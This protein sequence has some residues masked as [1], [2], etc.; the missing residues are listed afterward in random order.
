VLRQ[1]YLSFTLGAIR[2]R[3]GR[4]ILTALGIG[5]GVAAVLILT[6]IGTGVQKYVVGQF[7]QFGTNII[8]VQPGRSQTFGG[9]LGTISS[10]RPLTID[11]AVAL[12]RAPHVLSS[13]PMVQGNAEVEGNGRV[14][15]TT[16]MGVG[17]DM[18]RAFGFETAA[19]SFLP[20]D[21]PTAPRAVIVLGSTMRRELFGDANPLGAAVRVG[22]ERYRVIGVMRPKGAMI[23]FD[24]DDT[25][26][27]P[28]ARALSL[29]NRS[30][31]FEIDLMYAPDV[32]AEEVVAGVERIL[33]ARHGREDFTIVTQ[34]EMLD[35]L[36]SILGVL[37]TA[38]GAL[39]GISLLVGGVGI[40]T[41]ITIAVR[42][43][44][45]EIGLLRAL[46]SKRSQILV[47]FLG[48]AVLLAAL[49]G[50]GGLLLGLLVIGVI[51][52]AVP[53]LP[54]SVPL[55]YV[56]LAEA[57]AVAIGVVSGVLPA[58]RAAGSEPVE[59]LRAE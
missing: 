40:F 8:A 36:G 12:S 24:L 37:T 22:G 48:E 9:S 44:T 42:E 14:R 30:G 1:D 15:R 33:V 39:G 32:S 25:V 5:I 4:A 34:Q 13:V 49:G 29:F 20:A 2:A 45:A 10:L 35:V 56:V 27:I 7:T 50:V 57:I 23:G 3:R 54:V 43:R 6:S 28:A 38:V 59:A 18:A 58:I 26:Y 16:V 17:H 21:D 52:L 41:I 46:G 19:G 51:A 31:L 55:F 47:F 11:D 53:G